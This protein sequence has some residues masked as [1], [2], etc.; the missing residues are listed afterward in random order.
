[1]GGTAY[2]TINDLKDFVLKPSE[3][4]TWLDGAI[5]YVTAKGNAMT[6]AG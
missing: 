6:G 1:L 4:V 5:K 3:W 2:K